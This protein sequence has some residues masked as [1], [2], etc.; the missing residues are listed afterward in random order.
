MLIQVDSRE[1]A[2]AIKKIL[3][4]FEKRGADYFVSK[5][6]V[7][8]YSAYENP[9]LII[10]RKQNI[11]ELAQNATGGHARFKRE[12]LRLD[13]L[14]AKMFILTEQDRID[15]KPIKGIEDIILWKPVY[16]EIIGERVYRVL[17][18]WR[19]KH[20]VEYAFCSK[21]N[22]GKAILDILEGRHG[23]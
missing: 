23:T 11:G 8:D 4:E 18:A 17:H 22:T 16:G 2:R 9:L 10:D 21:R 6:Y 13:N 1:K 3:A 19:S 15:G 14:G 5:M 20:N 7:G 12:L